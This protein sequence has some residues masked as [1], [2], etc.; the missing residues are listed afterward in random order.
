[1]T[2]ISLVRPAQEHLP[3][4]VAALERGWLPDNVR[5]DDAARVE[6][7]DIRRDPVL[8]LERQIDREAKG[9]PITL[10]VSSVF[11]AMPVWKSRLTAC[12]VRTVVV[13]LPLS[14][15]SGALSRVSRRCSMALWKLAAMRSAASGI[16]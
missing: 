4:F 16:S 12:G 8:Y 15:A 2:P 13:E 11:G 10:P 14:G 6:M 1:M 5:G 3:G 9:P 7:A